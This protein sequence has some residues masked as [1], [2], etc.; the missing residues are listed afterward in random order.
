MPTKL[1]K[2]KQIFSLMNA[3][4][5]ET[6]GDVANDPVAVMEDGAEVPISQYRLLHQVYH[7]QKSVIQNINAGLL[8]IDPSGTITFANRCAAR[9]LGCE[10]EDLLNRNIGQF[11]TSPEAATKFLKL[12]SLPGRKLED[13]ETDFCCRHGQT[14]RVA[15]NASPFQDQV[16]EVQGIVVIFRDLTEVYHLRDRMERMERLALIGELAA[17][18]A[19]EIR[20]PLGGI[21]A[22]T[23][24]IEEHLDPGDVKS[25]LLQRIIEEVDKANRLLTEFF[26]FARPT[27]PK[28][29]FHSLAEL[30]DDVYLLLA[31]RMKKAEINYQQAMEEEVPRVYVDKTQIEQVILNLFLNAIEAMGSGGVLRVSITHKQVRLFDGTASASSAPEGDLSYVVMEISD[32]GPGIPPQHLEKIFNPFY[33]T[34]PE[35]LGLGLSICSRLVAEN[36]GKLD[37]SSKVGEGTTFMLAL[38]TFVSGEFH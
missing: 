35:G 34:K 7:F 36:R 5:P 29:A 15:L 16:N 27:R 12:C 19:H 6:A 18:I 1:E 31:P 23:Q 3:R 25:Q 28:P 20:N 21:K 9:L 14:M 11:F 8:T 10:V 22:A 4:F 33:T 37:V 17:G 32:T 24:V 30:V 2:Q 13:W 38:P 26:K